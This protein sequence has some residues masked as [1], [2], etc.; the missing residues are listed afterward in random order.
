MRTAEAPLPQQQ[1]ATDSVPSGALAQFPSPLV[2]HNPRIDRERV[3]R[4]D[5]TSSAVEGRWTEPLTPA[6]QG[7]ARTATPV[8]RKLFSAYH[9]TVYPM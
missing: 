6:W 2:S 3:H 5:E 1:A 4:D 8:I 9:E 7:F